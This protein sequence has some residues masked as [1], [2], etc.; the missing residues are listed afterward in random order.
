MNS[1]SSGES[2]QR[3]YRELEETLQTNPLEV[4]ISRLEDFLRQ[5]PDF[6]QAHNDL[7]VLYY[8][9]GNKLQTLG[10]Y[11]KAARLNPLN[12]TFRK[13]LASFYFVEMGWVDDAIFIYT[14]ILAKNQND[15]EV[16]SALG[17]ISAD[18]DRGSEARTFFARLLELEPW[19]NDAR[20]FLAELDSSRPTPANAV[21]TPSDTEVS[22]G[23]TCEPGTVLGPESRRFF[24]SLLETEPSNQSARSLLSEL[25]SSE[26]SA[27]AAEPAAT[28][29]KTA[30]ISSPD[31][32]A[33]LNDLRRTISKLDKQNRPDEIYA[34]ATSHLNQ[35][36]ELGAIRELERLVQVCPSHALAHNDLGVLFLRR[37]VLAK[38][39][40]YQELAVK[41]EPTNATFKKNL[42]GLYFAELGK[43]DEAIY[44]LT[45]ILR[46][47]PNDVETLTGLARIALAIG[48]TGEATTFIQKVTE[49]EP[50]N[51][52]ARELSGQIQ[53]GNS[54]FLTG[55]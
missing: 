7:A 32:D 47:N 23:S 34:N 36:D 50:W 55:S 17:I 12:N 45:D 16:L 40:Y 54:F 49:L 39:Q 3:A 51:D 43:T 29:T 42:A 31:L 35:G 2:A 6:A 28:R 22:Q 4:S 37:G 52:E 15:T 19:N 41:A 5:Y 26:R 1:F 44:L 21:A 48:R 30:E 8:R 18:L 25:N 24:T 46:T 9:I 10:H 38:S 13:N 33:I 14:D 11:E 27:P 53:G 20:A